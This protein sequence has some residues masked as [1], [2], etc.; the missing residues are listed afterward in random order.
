MSVRPPADECE[1]SQVPE[2]SFRSE[3][4]EAD[5]AAWL[6]EGVHTMNRTIRH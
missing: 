5:I 4:V 3:I 6:Q 2:A 1:S